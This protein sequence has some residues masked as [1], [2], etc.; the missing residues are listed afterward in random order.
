MSNNKGKNNNKNKKSKKE[1]IKFSKKH[2]KISLMIKLFFV[3][4]LLVVVV[5]AGILIGML[6]GG[7]GEEFKISEEELVIGGSNSLIVD[8]NGEKLAELSGDENRK[9]IR[10]DQ[11]PDN[12]KNAYIAIE[13]ER[14]YSHQ[15][16]DFKRTAAAIFQYIIHR[17]SSSF[18]GSTITQQLVKNITKDDEKSGKEG[19][20]RKVKEWA[21]AYQ[22]ERMIS[23][24]QILELYLNIIFVGGKTNNLGVEI[25][26][27]Y[28]FNKSAQDLD[29][30]EC[31]YLAGINHSPNSYNPFGETDNSEKIKN[32]TKTVLSKMLELGMIQQEDYDGACVEVDE[33]LKF[34]KAESLGSIYS[35]HRCNNCTSN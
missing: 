5:A 28:Y 16:V 14:F 24:E 11:M 18:G 10:L 6:Y 20:I 21:K 12:L 25:G 27:E 33:G 30:A 17:G 1:K 7:W 26:S 31:A 29:L 8:I 9:I 13:D 32:R 23:K 15:G 2:P 3:L 4:I 22:I 19:V 34:Q 35:Y